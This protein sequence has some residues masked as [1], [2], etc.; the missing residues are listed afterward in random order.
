LDDFPDAPPRPRAHD[1]IMDQ[2]AQPDR[3]S[4]LVALG[5]DRE[6]ALLL[7]QDPT[8]TVHHRGGTMDTTQQLDV[9]LAG[10]VDVASAVT[11]EQL[12]DPSPCTEFTVRGVFNHMIGGAG[13]FAAQFRG[14][15][16][17]EAPPEGTD[18]AGDDPVVTFTAA[19]E[20]LGASTRVPGALD[21]TVVAPFGEVPG[22]VAGRF[23]ALDGMVHAWDLATAT[24][25]VYD[26]PEDVV[27]EVL[28]FARQAIV[29]EMRGGGAFAAEVPAPPDA[30]PLEQLITFTGRTV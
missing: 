28:A 8:A 7:A 24:G 1:P 9:V 30:S 17:P 22:D 23:L 25:Q 2:A 15:A 19:M 6:A 29:P 16:P 21:R 12:D 5:R 20:A 26:P 3:V 18:L 14:E 13:F 4:R 27:V 10:L 11:P